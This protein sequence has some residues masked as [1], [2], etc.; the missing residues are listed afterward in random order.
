MRLSATATAMLNKLI[1]SAPAS[2]LKALLPQISLALRLLPT[3]LLSTV[4]PPGPHSLRRRLLRS[5]SAQE[6]RSRKM[7]F[8][9]QE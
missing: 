3:V 9:S 4:S 5:R 8:W 2:L 1:V 6:E 7:V